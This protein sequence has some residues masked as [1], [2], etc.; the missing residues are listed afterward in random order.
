[1]KITDESIEQKLMPNFLNN[2]Y[3]LAL[4]HLMLFSAITHV[5]LLIIYS[6][7]KMDIRYLNY[8][9]ILDFDLVFHNIINGALSQF[10]SILVIFTIYLIFFLFFKKAKSNDGIEITKPIV[11]Q[12]KCKNC[13]C[14]FNLSDEWVDNELCSEKCA[15]EYLAFVNNSAQNMS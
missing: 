4:K 6:I 12:G 1:M 9:D 5:L 7:I 14:Y 3:M 11:T 10:L 8:F 15:N 13:G 2:E